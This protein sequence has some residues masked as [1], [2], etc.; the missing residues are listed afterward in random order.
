LYAYFARP[1]AWRAAPGAAALLAA[2]RAEAYVVGIASN[3]DHRL[4]PILAGLDEL[5]PL[6][7][8]A[9]S[10]EVGWKKPAPEFFAALGA[11]AGLSPGEI[12]LVGDDLDNDFHGARRAGLA[13]LMLDPRG[14]CAVTPS[15]RALAEML[16]P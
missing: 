12:L 2:L 5:G 9:I 14:A 3:F 10:S 15:I 4:R 16:G 6:E 13:S 7:H 8:L 11:M 1:Q